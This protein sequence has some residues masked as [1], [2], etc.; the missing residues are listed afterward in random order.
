MLKCSWDDGNIP[1]TSKRI[2]N[3]YYKPI[4]LRTTE[5]RYGDRYYRNSNSELLETILNDEYGG[6]GGYLPH[7]YEIL[8]QLAKSHDTTRTKFNG[9]WDETDSLNYSLYK[10]FDDW[11][12]IEKIL[13]QAFY[14][15]PNGNLFKT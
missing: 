15:H 9:N 3:I 8:F 12:Y 2:H 6:Y 13:S 10:V 11:G 7:D 1:I 14:G 5:S 4:F